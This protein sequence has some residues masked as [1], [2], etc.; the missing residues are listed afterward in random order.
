MIVV[1]GIGAVSALGDGVGAIV[2][3]M[4][5][6]RD[7]L[8]EYT[9]D[10]IRA[11]HPIR[12]AGWIEG[13][14]LAD[15][16]ERAAREAWGQRTID[17]KRVAVVVGTTMGDM[18]ALTR[19]ADVAASAIGARGPRFTVSTACASGANA[20][21]LA[22]DLIAAGDADV[23]LAG[24][25]EKIV[26]G[27]IA[28]F[29]ALGVLSR[30]KCAPFGE[31]TGTTLGEGAGFVVLERAERGLV[32]LIGYGLSSDAFHETT[33]DPRGDGVAR[34]TL[35]CLRDASIEAREV[36]YVNAHATGT[37]AND[38]SEWRG[39]QRAL[40]P[41]AAEIPV[42][43]SK[44]F[45][46]HAQGAAGALEAIATIV[47]MRGDVIPPSLR[48]GRGRPRGPSDTVPEERPRA[49]RVSIALSNNA[50]FGGANAVLALSRDAR[51]RT[52]TV[53]TIS[54]TG[55]GAAFTRSGEARDEGAIAAS[56]GDADLRATDP[57]I[58]M[59]I[60]ASARAL[61][62]AG[63]RVSG[64]S[65]DRSGIFGGASRAPVSSVE[66]FKKSLDR[67]LDRA[68][69]PA[70][71]RTVGHAPVGVASR[72]LGL[73]GPLTMVAGEGVAGLLAIV[74]AARWLRDRDDADRILAG[75][76]DER[77]I[78]TMEEEG[79]M[80]AL[81]EAND[82][83]ALVAGMRTAG[84]EEEA[85]RGALAEAGIE[86][87]DAWERARDTSSFGSARVC[88]AAVRAIR[89]GAASAIASATGSQGAVAIVLK[90]R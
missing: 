21:G 39:I 74:Y 3:A 17:A 23:V 73:R 44:S 56:C 8:R 11:L 53:R 65:R 78:D 63:V 28:G 85:V 49:A 84:T 47:C 55:V 32:R 27:M 80:F 87:A 18:G 13:G 76:I 45:F 24:G 88:A 68:S 66:E 90:G 86:R 89:E 50:A 82:R 5:D 64:D 52:R 62:D 71:A 83:G 58:R 36:D 54:I 4:R 59:T 22:R 43:G 7:G 6:G 31:S 26:P 30:D 40:G 72:V 14:G 15:W 70:F 41:R 16:I 9:R 10:D 42:N 67:G 46:G 25:A 34:A 77:A 79:A 60:A 61:A 35:S 19:L 81:V 48:I 51:E 33:P 2:S 38:E 12:Y 29:A 1:T 75:G 20:I 37:A 57:A 69:A